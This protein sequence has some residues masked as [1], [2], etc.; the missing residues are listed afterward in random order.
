M[1]R[2]TTLCHVLLILGCGALSALAE[3]VPAIVYP[4][5]G[6]IDAETGLAAWARIYEVA[7]HPRCS[8]CHTGPSDVPMWSGPSYGETR[9]HGM[10]IR[11]G[12]SRFGADSL[13][14]STCHAESSYPQTIPHSAPRV[15]AKWQLAPPEADWFGRSS[16]HICAQLRDPARN[17]GRDY[18]ALAEHLGH[19]VVLHW[20]WDPGPGREPAPYS[21]R[22]HTMDMHIWGAAGQPCP[23]D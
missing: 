10:G 12:A 16:A 15:P 13:A 5:P 11:A 22:E 8:N 21:L 2:L 1:R 4:A 23:Q 9:P 18:A 7:S 20:A 17:G 14:C 6:T 3:D 19:D